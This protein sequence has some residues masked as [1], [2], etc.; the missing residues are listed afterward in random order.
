MNAALVGGVAKAISGTLLV[1][2][3]AGAFGQSLPDPTRPPDALNTLNAADKQE[4]V[5]AQAGPVLQSVLVSP[6]R[7]LVVIS[8]QTVK[9][10]GKYENARV[11]KI[12]ETEVVLRTGKDTRTLKLFPQIEKQSVSAQP[13]SKPVTG[14]QNRQQDKQGR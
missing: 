3:A 10:G 7:K 4:P 2:G 5:G 6:Q 9:L 14:Q 11:V 1:L 8:G 12:S 13:R